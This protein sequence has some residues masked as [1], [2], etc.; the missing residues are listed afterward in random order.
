MIRASL[1]PDLVV[2]VGLHKTGTTWLQRTIFAPAHDCHII[3][4]E[5]REKLRGVFLKPRQDAFSPDTARAV[6]D[7]LIS[8]ARAR[9]WPAVVSDEAL[10]GLP[11]GDR[12]RQATAFQR[13]HDT[14][15]QA[16]LLITIREQRRVL[17]SV[18]GHYL[19]GGGTATLAKFLSQPPPDRA[20]TW[21]P[22]V[23]LDYY[24]YSR[25]LRYAETIFGEGRVLMVP[26]EWML[27]KPAGL[28]TRLSE[29]F[30]VE[31]TGFEQPNTEQVVNSAW[32][33]L[34][35]GLNRRLNYLKV[36][37]PR[38]DMR[39]WWL[40]PNAVAA[41]VDQLTPAGLRR[42]Q[43]ARQLD[44][45]DSAVGNRY[46]ASNTALASRLNL[47]LTSFGYQTL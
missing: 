44:V 14:Y 23:D 41:R 39:T 47:D 40:K 9:G 1:F 11:F 5:T 16:G 26:M 21:D 42:R 2:H 20:A 10:G 12:F 22:I 24:D 43:K 28:L 38:W 17:Q 27:A 30:G 3:Y 25:L 6:L 8:E 31:W 7:P 46:A 45:I 4:S 19:R 32:S 33:T 35:Y 18:Y 36:G 29:T 34:G 13:L 15:P 37:E